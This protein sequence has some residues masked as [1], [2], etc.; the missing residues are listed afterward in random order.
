MNSRE[1]IELTLKH[2]IPDRVP[3]DLGGSPITGMHVS[4]VYKLRKALYLDKEDPPVKVIN[5]SQMLGEIKFDLIEALGIDVVN[6]SSPYNSYGYRNEKWKEWK[7]HDGTPVL[8]PEK[9]NTI[10]DRNGNLFMYP[11]GD[12]SAFA[13]AKMP[14]NGWYFDTIIR[15]NSVNDNN[16]NVE[17]NLEEFNYLPKEDLQYYKKN[18]EYLYNNTDK[19]IFANIGG[20]SFG[21]IA[22]VPAPNLKNPKGIRDIEEWYISTYTRKDYIYSIFEHQCEIALEN[23]KMFYNAVGN[24]VSIILVSTTDFGMQRGPFLSVDSYKELYKPFHKK[25][26]EWIH[27]NTKWKTFMHSCGSI[28]P[29]IGEFIDAGFDIL[30][31]VQWSAD[32]MK[33]KELK[34]KFG[35][36]ISFWGGGVNNQKT[37]SF[38]TADE[39]R[40]EVKKHIEIFAP[41]GGFVF[42]TIHNVQPQTPI[43]NLLA[44]YEAV[45]DYGQY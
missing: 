5:P 32:N 1:R 34:D 35:D 22:L 29:L 21:D 2:K 19:A 31:P 4:V 7:T 25:L 30:N 26:N 39:V 6:L 37:L 11:Q 10:P 33:P 40:E 16:L 23:I 36:Q 12:K 20:M 38:G 9:F 44:M 8:V 27:K 15:Q 43:K 13:C 3:L 24:K 17:D 45:K 42:N 18:A 14:E 28:M 41:G